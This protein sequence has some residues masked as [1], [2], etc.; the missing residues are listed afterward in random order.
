MNKFVSAIKPYKGFSEVIHVFLVI[1][2]PLTMLLF[3]ML[4]LVWL[5]FI[6]VLLSKWRILTVRSR[7]WPSLFR[8]NAVDLTTGLSI[9]AFMSVANS[10]LTQIGL[11]VAYAMWLLWLKPYSDTNRV[12]LQAAISQALGLVALF[13]IWGDGPTLGLMI[14]AWGVCYFSAYHFFLGFEEPR[15]S[16]YALSWGYFGAALVWILSHWLLFYG[17]V[18]QPTLILSFIGYGLAGL[19]YLDRAEKLSDL[20]KKQIVFTVVAIL[21][22]VLVFSNWDHPNL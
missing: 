5:A 12:A 21:I 22:V 19:Y 20:A 14:G 13:N 6:L 17:I 8:A 4:E 10:S 15:S 11:T 1:L 18:S 2:L 3:V 7:Y 16:L 9:L